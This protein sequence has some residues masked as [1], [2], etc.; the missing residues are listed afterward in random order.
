MQ[1]KVL[2]GSVFAALIIII[3]PMSAV[4]GSNII[5]SD[6]EKRSIASP[7]FEKRVDTALEKEN[8]KINTNYIGKGKI[9]NIFF[10][11][12]TTLS[13]WIDKSIKIINVKPR[14]LNQLLNKL[15]EIPEF[16]NLLVEYDLDK[17]VINKEIAQISGDPDAM[18]EK[19]DKVVELYKEKIEIPD[20]GSPQPL[21][22]SGQ[23][24]CLL[25]F[26]LVVFPM[27][28]FIVGL[29]TGILA[30]I[31]PG[32]FLVPGCLEW[33][34]GKVMESVTQGFQGLTPA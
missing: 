19:V 34:M 26:F 33:I 25:T 14:M 22:F 6:I 16:V 12:K 3:L 7:L 8:S 21:G 24:G 10:K 15:Y 4:V 23:L 20:I 1:K 27:I 2:V 18:R 31:I 30:L 32:T 5:K 29:L 11:Q 13:S 17:K 9:F 28:M